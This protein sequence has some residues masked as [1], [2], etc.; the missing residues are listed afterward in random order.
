VGPRVK[1]SNG[2]TKVRIGVGP[3][4]EA[5]KRPTKVFLEEAFSGEGVQGPRLLRLKSPEGL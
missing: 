1:T 3:R 2:P 4:V 5:S